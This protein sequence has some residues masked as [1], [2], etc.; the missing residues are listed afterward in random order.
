[1]VQEVDCCQFYSLITLIRYHLS[2]EKGGSATGRLLT[3]FYFWKAL[4][5]TKVQNSKILEIECSNLNRLMKIKIEYLV[6]HEY[7]R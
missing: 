2:E 7:R 6:L 5:E 3:M 4:R 1:M